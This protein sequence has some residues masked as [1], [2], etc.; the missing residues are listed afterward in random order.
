MLGRITQHVSA[1]GGPAAAPVASGFPPMS[2]V[3]ITKMTVRDI[4]FHTS[5]DS[6]G[7]DARSPDPDYSCAYIVLETSAGPGLQGVGL[8]FTI[9]RGNEVVVAAA[10]ILSRFVVGLDLGHVVSN[11]NEVWRALT[12]DGQLCWI[13][14]EKGPVHQAAA[15]VVNALWDMWGKHAGVPVWQLVAEMDPE[16][17]VEL[18]DFT[19]VEDALTKAEALAL[20]QEAAPTRPARTAEMRARG[21][22]AYTTSTGWAGYPDEKVAELVE[23]AMAKVRK[24]PLKL[25]QKSWANFSLL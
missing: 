5:K 11:F 1:R 12:N 15:G 18:L 22:P 7:S 23:G 8:A 21:F 13:G 19:Y 6:S 14:P 4:R 9:G 10:N 3:K 25:A 16:V 24:M 2:D 20:L 17:L